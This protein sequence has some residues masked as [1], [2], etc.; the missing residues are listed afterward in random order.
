VRATDK[1][2]RFIPNL[3]TLANLFLGCLGIIFC[4][5]DHVFPVQLNELDQ[6][7]KNIGVIFGFNNRLYLASFMIYAAAVLD[8]LDGFVARALKAQSP[9]GM[10]LDSLADGVTFGVLPACIYFQLLSGAYHL[11]PS[12]LYVP[13]ISMIPAFLIAL[14][15]VYRLAK[16]NVDERQHES[17]MGLPTPAMA[18]FA[19]SL[20]LIIFTNPYMLSSVILNKWLLYFL[21][22]AFS[23]LMVSELP[24]FSLKMKSFKWKGNELQILFGIASLLLILSMQY[25]GIAATI[26]LYILICLGR[27]F[28]G[29]SSKSTAILNSKPETPD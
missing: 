6:S 8:F 27:K 10:Q 26:L 20:P 4:F 28:L 11:E 22:V 29:N 23:W 19:A 24:M 25:T 7:G 18:I 12:A 2:I 9:L 15:A 21:V 16:F 14:C 1:L 17:F 5:N 3:F 13:V